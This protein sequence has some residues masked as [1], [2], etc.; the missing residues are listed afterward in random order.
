MAFI[1]LVKNQPL[2]AAYPYLPVARS[3]SGR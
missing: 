3:D 2:G 1:F